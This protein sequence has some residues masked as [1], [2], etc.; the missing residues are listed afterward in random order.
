MYIPHLQLIHFWHELVK[1]LLV[2]IFCS[3]SSSSSDDDVDDIDDKSDAP[4]CD[5]SVSASSNRKS[6]SPQNKYTEI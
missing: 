5:E 2:F 6:N 3:F 1:T 4:D